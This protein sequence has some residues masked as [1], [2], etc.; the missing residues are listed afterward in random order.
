MTSADD[1]NFWFDTIQ[2]ILLD[3]LTVPRLVSGHMAVLVRHLRMTM[4]ALNDRVEGPNLVSGFG[5]DQ[6][7][8]SAGIDEVGI[9]RVHDLKPGQ[10][11]IGP[12]NRR[13]GLNE[14]IVLGWSARKQVKCCFFNVLFGVKGTVV[15]AKHE[16]VSPDT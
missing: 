12:L 10:V 5:L 2:I 15:P 13:T 4:K 8:N 16:F 1:D 6:I 7:Q 9:E 3:S 14:L 11:R